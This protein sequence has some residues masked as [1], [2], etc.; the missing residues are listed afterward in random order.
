MK[1]SPPSSPSL[2]LRSRKDRCLS[3]ARLVP[4]FFS[5]M[6]LTSIFCLF[7]LYSPS[8]FRSI[9][10]HKNDPD[11]KLLLIKP[12]KEEEKCNL[13]EGRWIPDFEGSQYTNSSCATIPISKNCFRNGRKDR[14]FLNWRWKPEKCDLPRFDPK[15]FLE[16][17]RGK[18]LAFIG[19]SVARNHMES[20][21]CLLSQEEVPTDA[22]KDDED[23]NRVWHFPAHDFTLKILWTKFLVVGEERKINDSSSGIF[24][25][26]L[27]KID[28]NWARSLNNIDYII[29]SDGHWFFRPIYLHKGSEV[30]ACVYC[31]EPNVTD[32]GVSFAVS[33]ALRAAL[34]HINNCK[35]CKNIVTLWRTFSPSH[36]E[37][38]FWNTGG[39]CNRTSPVSEKEIDYGAREWELRNKQVDEV[40]R[41]NKRRQGKRFEVLDVTRA[42]LMR[43]D[44]HPGDFWGNK[45]MKGYNDCVH[46]CLPGP[47]DLWSDL[48]LAVLR[49]L[50]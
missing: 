29:I 20:L 47:I 26:Y 49:R 14:D 17:V 9:P 33:M 8:P 46:W 21:L 42:M 6:G 28:E 13:Y 11:E 4:F 48:L 25:L 44:G 7:L 3:M 16:I 39:S 24:D 15:A 12:E 23:R 45:W 37:N 40:E 31:N 27:D 32:K 19:D 38:G 18:T 30:V 5:S 1:S 10:K 43:P 36:F 35:K 34:N 22:Y 50:S 2:F 41:A